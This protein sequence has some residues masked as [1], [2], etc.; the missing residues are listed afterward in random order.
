MKISNQK[1]L[2]LLEGLPLADV[3]NETN[4]LAP[5]HV[6]G[7]SVSTEYNDAGDIKMEQA[8][9]RIAHALGVTGSTTNNNVWYEIQ[10]NNSTGVHKITGTLLNDSAPIK[11]VS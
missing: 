10:Y 4:F 11:I 1:A 9:R 5:L 7:R 2:E 3:S 6:K 8:K